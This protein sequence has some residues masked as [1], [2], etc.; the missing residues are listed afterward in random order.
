MSKPITYHKTHS[1]KFID[2]ESNQEMTI[3]FIT[4]LYQI[5]VYFII[6]NDPLQQ[7]G[8]KPNEFKRI[9]KS[10]KKQEENGEITDLVF[11]SPIT[12]IED[13]DGLWKE[14]TNE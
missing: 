1:Y 12:V 13:D 2:E 6:N 14:V 11:G 4:Q 9:E 7:G 3:N 5:G 8:I 10:L